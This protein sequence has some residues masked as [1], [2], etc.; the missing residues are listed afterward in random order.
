MD[1]SLYFLYFST[2]CIFQYCTYENC[3]KVFE[4]EKKD[5]GKA[6]SSKSRDGA[7]SQKNHIH[8]QFHFGGGVTQMTMFNPD[9]DCTYVCFVTLL[10]TS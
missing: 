5:M 2:Y 7:L 8:C 10:P 1:L 3:T 4:K 9:T 6:S